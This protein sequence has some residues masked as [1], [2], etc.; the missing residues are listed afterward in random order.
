MA[1][2]LVARWYLD[3]EMVGGEIS[4]WRDDRIPIGQT[5]KITCALKHNF[6]EKLGVSMSVKEI[7]DETT[8]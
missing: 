6:L 3:G 8:H 4:W 1:G 2:W 7:F 5:L